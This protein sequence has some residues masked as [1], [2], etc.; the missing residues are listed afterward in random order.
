MFLDLHPEDGIPAGAQWESQLYA[1]L[2]RCIAVV[3]IGTAA[4]GRSRWCFAEFALAR[5]LGKPIFPIRAEEGADQPLVDD[6]QGTEFSADRES[7]YAASGSGCVAS[8]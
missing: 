4:S 1:Q 6:L 2:R 5:S 8:A 7:D 3:Y